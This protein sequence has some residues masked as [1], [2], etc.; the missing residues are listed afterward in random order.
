MAKKKF[1]ALTDVVL[2][3]GTRDVRDGER[4]KEVIRGYSEN[5]S[6]LVPIVLD[7]HNRILDGFHR[8]HAHE[9][10]GE[11]KIAYTV[12]EVENDDEAVEYAITVNS[13]HGVQLTIE[14]IRRNAVRLFEMGRTPKEISNIVRR[15]ETVVGKY[16]KDARTEIENEF[17]MKV[18]ELYAIVD[19]NGKPI[20]S[21]RSLAEELDVDKGKIATALKNYKV[22]TSPPE[23][24]PESED[25]FGEQQLESHVEIPTETEPQKDTDSNS[26]VGEETVHR[27][28]QWMLLWLGNELNLNLWLPKKDLTE[29]HRKNE[30]INFSGMLEGLPFDILKVGRSV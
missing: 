10:A 24:E 26:E 25:N 5:I 29:S 23:P 11:E 30:I 2:W 7:Q 18:G 13:M 21:H 16:I 4:S 6:G 3:E 8:Y 9:H 15:H 14:E 20:Y 28:M 19:D 17:A 1:I 12:K 22:L 27:E